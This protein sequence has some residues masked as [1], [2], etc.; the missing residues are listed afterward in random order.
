MVPEGK[1]IPASVDLTVNDVPT[2]RLLAAQQ[3]F[4]VS[5]SSLSQRPAG[6]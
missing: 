1:Y 6:P 5:L 2:V 3:R 4:F